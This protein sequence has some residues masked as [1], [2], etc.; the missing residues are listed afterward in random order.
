MQSLKMWLV[1]ATVAAGSLICLVVETA[2]RI[3]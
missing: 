3:W 2:P 1:T